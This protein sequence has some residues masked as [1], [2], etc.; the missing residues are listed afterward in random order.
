MGRRCYGV[1]LSKESYEAIDAQRSPKSYVP[2]IAEDKI[3]TIYKL[4]KNRRAQI[5]ILA[6]LNDVPRSVILG[7]LSKYGIDPAPPKWKV[8]R[9]EKAMGKWSEEEDLYITEEYRK[10]TSREQMARTLGRTLLAVKAR[11]SV[12]GVCKGRGRRRKNEGE[13]TTGKPTDVGK[14]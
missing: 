14:V 7:V 1:N 9:T 13:D 3:V 12:L 8:E 5:S 2:W 4:A 6:Q 11:L 10:G